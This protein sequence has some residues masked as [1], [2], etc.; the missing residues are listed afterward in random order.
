[1]IAGLL[2]FALLLGLSGCSLLP[3]GPLPQAPEGQGR[4][5]IADVPFFPQDDFQ[6]GPA[7]LAMVLNWS[8][9][10]AQ[11]ADL[12]SEVY[13][14]DLKG[15]LQS[16]LV[17]AARRHGRVAYPISGS[18]ALLAEV[19]AGHPVLVL[20]NLGFFWYPKWHYAVVIGY[21]QEQREVVL[22][23]GRIDRETLSNR[24]FR[25]IWRRSDDWGLLVL[26]PERLPAGAAED[27]WLAAVAGLEGVGQWQAA[28]SGYAAALERWPE[29][30][31][32]WMG[33][34]NSNYGLHQLDD[35]AAA[36]R[37][38]TELQPENGLAYNNL[39]QVL[40]EQGQRR[41]ALA[42]AQRAV[43]L[44]GSY[45]AVFQQT[46]EEIKARPVN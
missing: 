37:R 9:I 25:N 46:Y 10:A 12:V 27:D 20:V 16:A 44:G 15:S 30:F 40:A 35:S 32:A 19:A 21:D 33:L 41:A 45:R 1:M 34:G 28:K 23:S 22:H 6:C 38:A 5:M 7:A 8:G 42:A 43:E 26:P 18:Q 14:P 2:F 11:P 17:G 4:A 13:S 36:F 31:V 29:S 39:A 3:D 24:V